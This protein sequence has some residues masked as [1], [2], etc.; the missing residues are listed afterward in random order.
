MR[1]YY[2]RDYE[3]P[4]SHRLGPYVLEHRRDCILFTRR[5]S[6]ASR[7][8]RARRIQK[9]EQEDRLIVLCLFLGALAWGVAALLYSRL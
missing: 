4:P 6:P 9:Q 1:D 8:A 7:R 3:P 5:R 2:L